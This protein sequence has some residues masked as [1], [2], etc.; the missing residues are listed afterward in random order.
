M[1]TLHAAREL[2]GPTYAHAILKT[3]EPI[4]ALPSAYIASTSRDRVIPQ[5]LVWC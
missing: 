2:M 4:A 3:S 1:T 5:M